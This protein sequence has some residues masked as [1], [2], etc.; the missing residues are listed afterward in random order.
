MTWN[1]TSAILAVKDQS[2]V[3][4]AAI[5]ALRT[6]YTLCMSGTSQD[7]HKYDPVR[8]FHNTVMRAYAKL[9]VDLGQVMAS[10]QKPQD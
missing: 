3:A 8:E 1:E 9:T 10:Q 5:A 6:S 2:E 7:D 4:S